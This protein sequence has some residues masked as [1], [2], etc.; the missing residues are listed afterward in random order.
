M[1]TA[2]VTLCV[3]ILL[4]SG[5]TPT[6][7]DPDRPDDSSGGEIA[8]D[9]DVCVVGTWDLDLANYRDQA[10]AYLAT[11]GVPIQDLVIDGSQVLQVG[12]SGIIQVETNVTTSGTIV[13]RDY[14]G[15]VSAHTESVENGDWEFADDGTLT[16][17]HWTTVSEDPAST[18]ATEDVPVGAVDFSGMPSVTALC[19]G[20]SLFLQG[21]DAP[22]GS[23][24][25]RR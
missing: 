25:T 3:A 10:E 23:Y 5:C 12:P 11:T 20:D 2:T 21:Q 18:D 9:A 4:L 15:P 7:P 14:T 13:V 24:W 6:T 17:A 8:P 16:I 1:K 22:L 19:D